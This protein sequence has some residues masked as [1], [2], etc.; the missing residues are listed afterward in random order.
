MRLAV[1]NH[2]LLAYASVGFCWNLA[3]FGGTYSSVCLSFCELTALPA[4]LQKSK[5]LVRNSQPSLVSEIP[6]FLCIRGII[7]VLPEDA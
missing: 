4:S 7:N 2:G 5:S 3:H 6:A 1:A